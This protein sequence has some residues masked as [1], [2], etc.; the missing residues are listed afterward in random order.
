[1]GPGGLRL[2]YSCQS[3]SG[4][5][6]HQMILLIKNQFEGVPMNF[7]LECHIGCFENAGHFKCCLSFEVF[8]AHH[9]PAPNRSM[10]QI[11]PKPKCLCGWGA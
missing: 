2:G 9:L 4:H 5:F 6:G 1:M 7:L 10:E 11:E 3:C 8:K